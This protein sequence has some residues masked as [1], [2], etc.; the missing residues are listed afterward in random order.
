MNR[1]TLKALVFSFQ[2][3]L[4]QLYRDR[5][6]SAE[7]PVEDVLLLTIYPLLTNDN[8]CEGNPQ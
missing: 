1:L 2:G 3:R 4:G 8:A 5:R 7:Y 6:Q